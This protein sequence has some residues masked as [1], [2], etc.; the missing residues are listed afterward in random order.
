MHENKQPLEILDPKL[1]EFNQEEVM[2]V[3]NVILLCTMGLPHQRPPM[4]KVVS[5]LTEDIETVEVEANARP[6]YIPQS[7]IRSENDGFIAG[8]FSGSS[9]QQSS[10]TQGSMPSSS[11]SKPKFHRDTSPLA[12][13]PCSSCEIDEGR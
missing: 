2:R 12:L 11:S 5:I 4:S 1:T 7:Q 8:Y 10:G 13:S 3:I 9:I 6:S